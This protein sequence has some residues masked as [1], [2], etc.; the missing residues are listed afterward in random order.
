MG[1]DGWIGSLRRVRYGAPY[2]TIKG[3]T[4]CCYMY[5]LHQ[6]GCHSPITRWWPPLVYPRVHRRW[7]ALSSQN[8]F[9]LFLDFQTIFHLQQPTSLIHPSIH[10]F[11]L[12]KASNQ[13]SS[14]FPIGAFC[15]QPV[16]TF[17][18]RLTISLLLIQ[19]Q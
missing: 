16:P 13:S 19:L 5:L 11:D 3:H 18:L 8:G 2:T 6:A 10:T 12:D 15:Q 9:G 1:L 4:M 7:R 14:S 17:S